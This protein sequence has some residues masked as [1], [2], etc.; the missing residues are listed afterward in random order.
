VTESALSHDRDLIWTHLGLM[1]LGM[2]SHFLLATRLL[3][4]GRQTSAFHQISSK[5]EQCSG[6]D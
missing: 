4:P 2:R 6:V 3:T 1:K 5:H